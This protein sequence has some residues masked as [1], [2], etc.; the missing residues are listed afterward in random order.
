MRLGGIIGIIL[1]VG[2][3]LVYIVNTVEQNRLSSKDVEMIVARA[4]DEI[5]SKIAVCTGEDQEVCT[6]Q[7]RTDVAVEMGES[8]IC[9]EIADEGARH[10]CASLIAMDAMDPEACQYLEAEDKA[11]CA[12]SVNLLL[13]IDRINLAICDLISSERLADSCRSQV[14]TIIVRQ[15]ACTQYGINPSLCADAKARQQAIQD[16][17]VA[18]DVTLCNR[19]S[20]IVPE[21]CFDILGSNDT[22]GDGLDDYTEMLRFGTSPLKADTDSD[23]YSDLVEVQYGFDPFN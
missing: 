16:I 8:A 15:N 13:G 1:V 2:L 14:T 12:D 9:N 5:A 4:E 18:G 3:L 22:D 11:S 7:I 6:D 21:D 19:I 17:L 23:G 10:N 20:E